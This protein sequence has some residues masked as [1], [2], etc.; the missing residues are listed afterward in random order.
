[1]EDTK[2]KKE[3]EKESQWCVAIDASLIN[4]FEFL[5]QIFFFFFFFLI[6]RSITNPSNDRLVISIVITII[7]NIIIIIII[8]IIIII[9][10][11]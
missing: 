8:T 1:M 7:I 11:Y 5:R 3:R 4:T 10:D 6:D 2:K 9:M